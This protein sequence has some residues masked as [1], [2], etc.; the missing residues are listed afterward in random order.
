MYFG[1]VVVANVP[2]YRWFVQEYAFAAGRYEIGIR[3]HY[4]HLMLFG[5]W[6]A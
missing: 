2:S 4:F 3:E 1:A 6:L 5:P